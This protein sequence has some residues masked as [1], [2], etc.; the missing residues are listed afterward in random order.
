MAENQASAFYGFANYLLTSPH[1][2]ENILMYL[3]ASDVAICL[4]TCKLFRRVIEC[5]VNGHHL[6]QLLLHKKVAGDV[7]KSG[8]WSTTA[9]EAKISSQS[10]NLELSHRMTPYYATCRGNWIV[11][12][13][14]TNF[15]HRNTDD[16]T[17]CIQN[18]VTGRSFRLTIWSYR[19]L[20]MLVEQGGY[21]LF[22]DSSVKKL[23]VPLLDAEF[24]IMVELCEYSERELEYHKMLSER[25]RSDIEIN[26]LKVTKMQNR[27]LEEIALKL[28]ENLKM[29]KDAVV[30]KLEEGVSPH[31]II[32]S[33]V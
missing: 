11:L 22:S 7:C 24:P 32:K 8:R 25:L 13:F 12:M 16:L 3:E 10:L 4:R 33:Q 18:S 20:Q 2:T 23:K 17:V 14:K 19:S 30:I 15:R 5:A 6:F 31:R 9:I 1:V 27:R 26:H 28:D 29:A 21:L